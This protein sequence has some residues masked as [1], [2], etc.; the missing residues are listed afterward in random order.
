M[1]VRNSRSLMHSL[2]MLGSLA[3]TDRLSKDRFTDLSSYAWRYPDGPLCQHIR[4]RGHVNVPFRLADESVRYVWLSTWE[5]LQ[6]CSFSLAFRVFA[7]LMDRMR[8]LSL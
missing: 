6:Q 4:N 1:I 3:F 5:D 7:Y 2:P 8:I